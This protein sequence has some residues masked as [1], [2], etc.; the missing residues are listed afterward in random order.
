VLLSFLRMLPGGNPDPKLLD[1]MAETP[2]EWTALIQDAAQHGVLQ[3]IA[4]RLIDNGLPD[5]VREAV[6]QQLAIGSMW[7]RHLAAS[8]EEAV[9]VLSAAGI[10]P[11]VLKGP[12]LAERLYDDPAARPCMDIDLLVG[13][14]DLDTA[15]SALRKAGYAGDPELSASYLIRH[16]HHL[17]FTR[18]GAPSIE[19][20]FRAYAGFGTV[21]PARVLLD[22]ATE[23]CFAGR[24]RVLV[25]AAEDEFVYLAIHAAGHCF[26]RLLWLYDL[27]LLLRRHPDLDW[28]EIAARVESIGVASA[29]GYSIRLVAEWLDAPAP[30][31]P[32]RLTRRRT[33]ARLA[34]RLLA[35]VSVPRTRSIRDNIGGLVF[36]SLLCDRVSATAWLLQ[37]HIGRALRHRLQR[38]APGYLP[39]EWAA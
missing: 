36:T 24:A 11:A 22:R 19:L 9:G 12:V 39:R 38:M 26:V 13:P 8:L 29:V 35:E 4:P 37:H 7:Q 16:A 1:C 20:H 33:R 32:A 23:Y 25:P 28:D 6:D 18:T 14:A 10:R 27:K 21:L 31:L 30:R 2:E 3:L 15:R 5:R 17:H 34:D